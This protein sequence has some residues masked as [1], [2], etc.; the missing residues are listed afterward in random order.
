MPILPSDVGGCQILSNATYQMRFL[1]KDPSQSK[2]HLFQLDPC[3]V[4]KITSTHQIPFDCTIPIVALQE[5]ITLRE[6]I[7]QLEAANENLVRKIDEVYYAPGMPGYLQH[8]RN[9]D[10]MEKTGD[11]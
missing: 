8:K 9:F 3:S 5:I 10:E 11:Y 1:E 6:R 4:Q 7:S 2:A